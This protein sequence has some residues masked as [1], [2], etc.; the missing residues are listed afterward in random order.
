VQNLNRGIVTSFNRE[1]RLKTHAERISS[2]E[3]F[4]PRKREQKLLEGADKVVKF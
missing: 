1:L 3:G 2:G 4:A